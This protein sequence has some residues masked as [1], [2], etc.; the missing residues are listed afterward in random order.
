MTY[1]LEREM[2]ANYQ[3]GN[4]KRAFAINQRRW[5]QVCLCD[6]L[7]TLILYA[8]ANMDL[9]PLRIIDRNLIV[10]WSGGK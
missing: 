9:S 2:S 3:N 8:K 7:A 4:T 1:T 10:V 5:K 6:N